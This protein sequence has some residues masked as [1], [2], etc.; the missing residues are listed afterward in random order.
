MKPSRGTSRVPRRVLLTSSLLT[1][2][3]A[4]LGFLVHANFADAGGNASITLKVAPSGDLIVVGS[5]FQTDK[6]TA[7][8]VNVAV[9]LD[10]P[11]PVVTP[12]TVDE[13]GGFTQVVPLPAKYTGV[14]AATAATDVDSVTKAIVVE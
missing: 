4:A 12:V 7:K 10:A 14:V 11:S 5:G 6:A 2:A 13:N 3:I 9:S 8:A 1:V